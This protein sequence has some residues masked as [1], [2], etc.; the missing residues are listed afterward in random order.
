MPTHVKVSHCIECKGKGYELTKYN[1]I[2]AMPGINLCPYC[3]GTGHLVEVI[4]DE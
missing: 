2:G 4:E 3:G 1:Q